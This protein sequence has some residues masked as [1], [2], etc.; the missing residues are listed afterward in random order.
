MIRTF[1]YPL[2]PNRAQELVLEEQ[3][4]F[5]QQLYNA[6]LQERRDAYCRQHKSISRYAQ[7][8]SLTILRAEDEETRKIPVVVARSAL[9]RV[10]EAYKGFFRRCKSG[11]KPGFPR[12][13]SRDRYDSFSVHGT[14]SRDVRVVGQHVHL[15]KI[16]PVRFKK[17]RPIVGE[18]LT[19]TV[20]RSSRGWYV[21]FVCDVGDAPEKVAV[22]PDRVT[23]IDLG[24]KV[25]ATLSN[26]DG[27]PN[28][29]FFRRSEEKLARR[30]QALARKK[31]GSS[32]RRRAKVLV[33]RA[34]DHIKNQRLDHARKTAKVL[35]DYYD[36][37]AYEDLNIRGM[38][39]SLDGRLAKSINDVAWS[40][41]IRCLALKA[42]SAGK[43]LIAVDPRGTTQ[44]CSGCE[45]VVKKTLS[46]RE[47]RCTNPSCGLVL[48]RDHN[49][50]INILALGHQS[51][52][53]AGTL[54][55]VESEASSEV[56]PHLYHIP[57][58]SVM[59]GE[60]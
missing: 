14:E 40:T 36:L 20:K 41:F 9:H 60:A 29:R 1:R 46:D 28:P 51:V 32:S 22:R 48:D 25:F 26:G 44:R 11:E 24:L 39:S 37:I 23:G 27:V 6:A 43:H 38:V 30:Q 17:Y 8:K 5:C 55:P 12:F 53:E 4:H 31:R 13:R 10:D 21:S 2:K 3:L 15:P 33:A 7:Q 35:F 19:V 18:I 42:E 45:T 34:Y 47:H 49:A 50:A 52:V 56:R 57:V 54:V 16:G 59:Q 58:I